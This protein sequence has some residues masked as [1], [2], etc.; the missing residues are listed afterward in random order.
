MSRGRER[1]GRRLLR[2]ALHSRL[3]DY[4]VHHRNRLAHEQLAGIF[5]DDEPLPE[6]R[7]RLAIRDGAATKSK[8]D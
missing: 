7:W 5:G 3:A 4:L 8:P 1:L 6:F 2:W